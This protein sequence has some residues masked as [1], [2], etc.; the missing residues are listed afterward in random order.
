MLCVR[1]CAC[2]CVRAC[3]CVCVCV[4]LRRGLKTK[5][6]VTKEILVVFV[7][8]GYCNKIPQTEWPKQH[9]FVVSNFW[10]LKIQDPGVSMVGSFQGCEGPLQ[11]SP[12][13]SGGSL[14]AFGVPWFIG[15]ITL[16]SIFTLTWCSSCVC[17]HPNFHFS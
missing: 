13:S 10:R 12:S 1:V 3:V 15:S 9:K 6:A 8:W 4:C 17:V 2:V 11:T 14:A 16:I 5:T 7:C